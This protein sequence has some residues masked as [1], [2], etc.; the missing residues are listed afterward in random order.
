MKGS[1]RTLDEAHDVGAADCDDAAGDE[2]A[3]VAD[4][5]DDDEP[6]GVADLDFGFLGGL[7]VVHNALDLGF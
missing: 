5:F 2:A 7:R 6:P 1:E 4:D 3:D